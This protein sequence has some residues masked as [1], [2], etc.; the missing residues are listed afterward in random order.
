MDIDVTRFHDLHDH[1]KSRLPMTAM[2]VKAAARLQTLVPESHRV[3]FPTIFGP[4]MLQASSP[5]VNLPISIQHEG[6]DILSAVMIKDAHKKSLKE[7]NQELKTAVTKPLEKYPILNFIHQRKNNLFNRFLLRCLYYV[8]YCMPEA[9]VK[10][11]GGGIC[12][13]SLFN[14]HSQ[15]FQL[16]P[17]AFGPTAI[18]LCFSSLEKREGKKIL[19]I[20]IG[21]DHTALMGNEMVKALKVLNEI[22]QE[23]VPAVAE[24][25]SNKPKPHADISL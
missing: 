8:A 7:I 15:E 23:E 19:K 13:S 20:G 22:L 16:R 25:L 10:R 17:Y 4:R 3:I 6:K 14:N 5:I 21:Y 24:L 1:S 9:Y 11:G 2:M 18:T 12:V